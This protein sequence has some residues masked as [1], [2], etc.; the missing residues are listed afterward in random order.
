M[1]YTKSLQ[2]SSRN[3][4]P[5]LSLSAACGLS[6]EYVPS[7]WPP[8]FAVAPVTDYSMLDTWQ[9]LL[10]ADCSATHIARPVLSTDLTRCSTL[11]RFAPSA[12]CSALDT[13]RPCWPQIALCYGLLRSSALRTLPRLRI[14]PHST[15]SFP[16]RSRIAP[17][18]TPSALRRSRIAPCS[19]LGPPCR[20]TDCSVL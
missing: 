10:H 4:K 20:S 11:T 1:D 5:H 2:Q 18:S 15:L 7:C 14:A 12:D 3:N 8:H 9:S 19:T 17:S 16:R 13:P 6:A